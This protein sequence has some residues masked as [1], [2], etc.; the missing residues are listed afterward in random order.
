MTDTF[1]PLAERLLDTL[2]AAARATTISG[3]RVLRMPGDEPPWRGTGVR[4]SA[5]Q[6][7]SVFADGCIQWSP[8]RPEL[9]GGPR[10]HL[11]A[12][13]A[14]GGRIVKLTRSTG[15]FVADVAGE[16]ELG[17]Y[18]GLWRNDR[19]ELATSPK[20]YERLTGAIDAAVIAWRDSASTGLAA[21]A[22]LRPEAEFVTDEI[23]HLASPIVPPAGWNYLLETGPAE[24]FMDAKGA[25]GARVIKLDAHDDQGIVTT[26]VE[27]ALTAHTRIRWRWRVDAHPSTRAEDAVPTHDYIS[28]AA[29]F[30]NGRDLTWIWSS[31]LAPGTHFHCPVK[32]WTARE[33][34]FVVRSGTAELGTWLAEERDIHRDV[35]LAMGSPPGRIVRVWLIAVC[36]FQHGTARA[37]FADIELEN[38]FGG[39]PVL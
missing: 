6:A 13:I 1:L 25:G 22:R 18:M 34:H 27:M 19:G 36:S 17:I 16:I 37:E 11:W 29:E 14:P 12:R 5:G 33:T 2:P 28:V 4:V 30:D 10:Y 32:A 8:Q 23:V 15:S 31:Q 3:S 21:L 9:H 38:E 35:T 26:P 20:L 7:Y 24:I 39:I